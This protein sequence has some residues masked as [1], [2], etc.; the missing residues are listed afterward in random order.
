MSTHSTRRRFLTH[1]GA[2]GAALALAPSFVIARGA[3][4][5]ARDVSGPIEL[6]KLPYSEDALDPVISSRTIG[7]HY[8]K[9]HAGYVRKL[10][11]AIRGSEWEGKPLETIV[12]KAHAAGDS[13]RDV[14]NNAAQIWNHT[15]YWQSMRPGG[16]GKPSGKVLEA[17][18]KSFGGYEK[19]REQFLAT[20]ASQFG[21][22][23]GWLVQE[24]DGSH[25][26]MKTANAELPQIHGKRPLMTVDVWEHAYYLD[27]QNKRKAYLEAFLDKLVNWELVEK[28]L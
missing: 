16:G 21:S 15:F 12:A 28:S 2:S 25:A 27:W 4:A 24:K 8:G 18:E 11:A 22:G 5:G 20:S 1:L 7:F 10:N 17:L 6:P 3:R 14:F 13:K 19:F 9:H 26:V 23:W